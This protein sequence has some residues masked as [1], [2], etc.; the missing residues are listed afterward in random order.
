MRIGIDI[1]D[2]I[3]R[4]SDMIIDK[5]PSLLRKLGHDG[6][7]NRECYAL[8]DVFGLNESDTK[9]VEKQLE[10]CNPNYINWDAINAMY[11]LKQTYSDVDFH[12][13]TWRPNADAYPVI[14]EIQNR[15]PDLFSEIHCLDPGTNKATFCDENG[16]SVMF[17]DYEENILDF[18]RSDA[19]CKAILISPDNVPHNK[20]FAE[21]YMPKLTN[22]N[23][24]CEIYKNIVTTA[25]TA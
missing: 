3:F 21:T 19:H 18:Q 6:K 15:Y 23:D 13:V 16:I 22:W 25:A 17:D 11:D 24:L 12:I 7:L 14:T 4:T 1:D 20:R 9:T 5:A 2:V 8:K 10:W